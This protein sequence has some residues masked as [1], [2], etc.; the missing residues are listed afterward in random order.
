MK[1]IALF[2]NKGGV[3][4]TT[5]L[6]H[7]AHLLAS[8]NKKVL[9]VDCDS[10]CNLTEYAMDDQGIERCWNEKG[11]SIYQ[12]IENVSKGIGDYSPKLPEQLND[13]LYIVPGDLLLS[14]YED[15]LGE[16]WTRALGGAESSLRIQAAI[17]RYIKWAAAQ[18]SADIVLVDLG[19]NLGSLNRAILGGCD[20]FIVPI[21]PDLF[22]IRGTENL[23]NK[24]LL[25]RQEWELCN[26][27]NKSELDIPLG[28]PAFMGYVMQQQTLR[29]NNKG[30]TKGW[31][32]FGDKLRRAVKQNIIEKL[33][34]FGQVMAFNNE[35]DLELDRIPNLNSLIPY[36]LAA[37]KPIFECASSDGLTGAHITRAKESVQYFN[38]GQRKILSCL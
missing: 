20:Y 1:M 33:E 16:S 12:V 30:M 32:I 13:N 28:K 14:N 9:M 22:S 26:E 23:G 27:R 15:N 5:Y 29:K 36:S 18:V 6:Y 35:N 25:W 17:Y 11:N 31:S 7:A 4:K 10:Q 37:G 24:L 19:P 34:P 21:A 8:E 38:K 2:N 3:G